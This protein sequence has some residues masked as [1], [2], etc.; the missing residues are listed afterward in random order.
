[1]AGTV[2]VTVTVTGT[3]TDTGTGTLILHIGI[4]LEIVHYTDEH[5]SINLSHQI[6]VNIYETFQTQ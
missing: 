3:D 6:L 4:G 5:Y 2:T 1:M